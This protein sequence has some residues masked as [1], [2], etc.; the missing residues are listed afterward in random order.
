MSFPEN[1]ACGLPLVSIVTPS[2]NQGRFIRATIESVLSQNYPN[3]EYMIIDAGS[4]DETVDIIK[5][6]NNQFLWVSEPDRGQAHAINKG[7][8]RSS[9]EILAWLNSD[10][11]YLPGAIAKAVAHFVDCPETGIVY[12]EGNYIDEYGQFIAPYPTEPFSSDRLF[13]TCFICQPASFIR[14]SVL[15]NV[16]YLDESLHY[17][18][19]YDLW[20]RAARRHQLRYLN[21]PLANLRLYRG[22]KSLSARPKMYKEA[23]EILYRHYGFVP[24]SWACGYVYRSLESSIDRSTPLR[25]MMFLV[26]FAGLCGWTFL[27]YNHRMPLSEVARWKRGFREGVKKLSKAV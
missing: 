16:G 4:T 26:L 5:S 10:D 9:G 1:R 24:P 21:E 18:M 11:I 17:C 19:D 14:R 23:L 3:V 22:A 6:Y 12:G 15:E 25:K 20:I 7:W 2:F 27:R 13:E 8:S